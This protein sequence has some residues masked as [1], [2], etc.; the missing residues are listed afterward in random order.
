MSV[1]TLTLALAT[2][3]QL[4]VRAV[5]VGKGNPEVY[6]VFYKKDGKN[7][8]MMV[9]RKVESFEALQR[10]VAILLNR[11]NDAQLSIGLKDG[12]YAQQ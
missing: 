10:E 1:S 8:V 5:N 11:S 7:R 6:Q 3:S 2:F 9:P 12:P 4:D